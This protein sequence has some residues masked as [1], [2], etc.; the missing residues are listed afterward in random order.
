MK[1]TIMLSNAKYMMARR[2]INIALCIIE[3][4][5]FSLLTSENLVEILSSALVDLDEAEITGQTQ[6]KAQIERGL[7]WNAYPRV[8]S[9]TE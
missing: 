9:C 5:S 7:D 4:G 8:A 3:D 6:S 2:R 1:D